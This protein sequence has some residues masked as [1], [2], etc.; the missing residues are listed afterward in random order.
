MDEFAALDILGEEVVDWNDMAVL[1][2]SYKSHSHGL[3][4]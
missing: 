2:I 1:H 3:I 4:F